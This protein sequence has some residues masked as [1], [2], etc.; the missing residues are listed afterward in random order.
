MRVFLNGIVVAALLFL[1]GCTPS[2]E[3]NVSRLSSPDDVNRFY[4]ER[5]KRIRTFTG[6]GNITIETPEFSNNAGFTVTINRPDSLLIKLKGPFGISV[7]ILFITN[8][9]FVFLNNVEK[10]IQTGGLDSIPIQSLINMPFSIDDLVNIFT[11]S[12]GYSVM[13]YSSASLNFNGENYLLENNTKAERKEM[14]L[15]GANNNFLKLTQRDQYGK[16]NIEVSA[17]SYENVNGVNLPYWTRIIFPK[18]QRSLTIAYDDI[19]I[20][21]T[22]NFNLSLPRELQN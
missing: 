4:V 17:R 1:T 22:V 9:K 16:V 15:D 13:D 18:Q 2:K 11:G 10:K 21:D 7:G 19:K 5:E 20:N 12:Y 3:I 6:S 14:I 8:G